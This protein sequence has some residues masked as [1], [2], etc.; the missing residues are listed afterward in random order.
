MAETILLAEIC[1]MNVAAVQVARET[2]NTITG[3]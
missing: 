2:M 1:M 3:L